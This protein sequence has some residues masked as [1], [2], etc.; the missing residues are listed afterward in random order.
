MKVTCNGFIGELVKLVREDLRAYG[1]GCTYNLDIRDDKKDVTYSFT[2]VK[3]SDIR[4]S[5]VEVCF[6]G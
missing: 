2:G 5:G 6:G 1:G 4:F 3:L